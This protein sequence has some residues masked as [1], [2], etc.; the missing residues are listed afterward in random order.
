MDVICTCC[1]EPWDVYHVLHEEP[2]TFDRDGCLI[3]ACLCCHG[4]RPA[5]MPEE[6]QERLEAIKQLAIMLGED[7]DGFAA[8]L[9]DFQY[10]GIL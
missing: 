4:V 2:D 7:I 10:A 8:M 3:T 6:Y 9:E 5:D 1:G